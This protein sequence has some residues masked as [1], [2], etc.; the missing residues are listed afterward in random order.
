ANCA[1]C[2][3]QAKDSTNT[4]H[5]AFGVDLTTASTATCLGCHSNGAMA[6]NFSHTWFPTAPTDIHAL[7]GPA[8]HV[9]GT[10]RCESCHISAAN[11]DYAPIDC[12]SCHAQSNTA[13]THVQVGGFAWAEVATDT[14]ALCLRCH[15]DS[16][17]TR[18]S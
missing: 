9:G 15:A 14:S 8:V 13:P 12:T 3:S 1:N 7:G 11:L 4:K 16:Q 17:V 10:I 5:G 18:I 2:H 6:T